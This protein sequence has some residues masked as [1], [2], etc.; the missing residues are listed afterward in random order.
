[1]VELSCNVVMAPWTCTMLQSH[2]PRH[3]AV[4]FPTNSLS[5][6]YS[7]HFSSSALVR[8]RTNHCRSANFHRNPQCDIVNRNLGQA[9]RFSSSKSGLASKT[10]IGCSYFGADNFSGQGRWGQVRIV[11]AS[12][13]GFDQDP[14]KENRSELQNPSDKEGERNSKPSAHIDEDDRSTTTSG[15]AEPS[16]SPP[17][18]S[19]WRMPKWMWSPNWSWKGTPAVQAHEIGALLLRLSIFVLLMRLLRVPFSGASPSSTPERSSSTYVTVPF[20][21]FLSKSSHND[22]ESVEIDGYHLTY[23]LRPSGRQARLQKET[24]VI[25]PSSPISIFLN[26][27][28]NCE[29]FASE[30]CQS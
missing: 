29:F 17:E 18:N 26:I 5:I 4:S 2:A 12:A 14:K 24:Q 8:F 22:I 6:Q 9:G 19:W 13:P 21:E 11:L 23:S 25:L 15:R 28:T 16:A 30:V 7:L 3:L 1:M 27:F 20:S 10:F